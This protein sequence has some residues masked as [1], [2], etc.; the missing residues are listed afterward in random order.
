MGPC[1]RTASREEK[2]E[3]GSWAEV[4]RAKSSPQQDGA[5]RKTGFGSWTMGGKTPLDHQRKATVQEHST[6]PFCSGMSFIDE[7][8]GQDVKHPQELQSDLSE[9]DT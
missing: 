1:G 8:T 5:E 6:H 2:N 3:V 4:G 9:R 7:N